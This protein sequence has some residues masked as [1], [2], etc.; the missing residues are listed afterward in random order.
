[1]KV[2]VIT[3][4]HFG[5][6]GDSAPFDEYFK[7][8]YENIFFPECKKRDIKVIIHM[9]D[10]FD[11]RKFINFNTLK[12]CQEYFFQQLAKYNME[13]HMLT[14]NHD[15]YFKNTNEVNSLD[16]LLSKYSRVKTYS[17]PTILT[18]RPTTYTTDSKDFTEYGMVM[19]PWIC[20]GNYEKAM[21]LVHNTTAP[22]MFSHLELAGFCMYK[23]MMNEHGM[24]ASLFSKFD[25][26]YTGHFHTRSKAGNIHYLGNPYHMTWND[27][28]D[29]RGFT[30]LDL[31]TLE[32]EFVTNPYEIFLK[33]YYDDTKVDPTTIDIKQFK[34]KIVKLIVSNKTDFAKYDQFMD[35][36]H[37]ENILELKIIEDFSEFEAEALDDE[38]IDLEDTLSLLNNYVDS[39]EA[40]FDKVRVK[41]ILKELYIEAQ[42]SEVL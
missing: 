12:S 10:V 6:R 20:S 23:G 28:G 15:T 19:M 40:D 5:A 18:I 29:Q 32:Q 35:R 39:V 21:E 25:A 27:Y 1:M 2:A 13:C 37:A 41:T 16:L 24:D 22:I 4:T 17:E 7:N 31:Q 3:D 11:R 30:V 26:V 42:H 33:Y 38:D 9:G 34:D 36:L 14:G 8:F